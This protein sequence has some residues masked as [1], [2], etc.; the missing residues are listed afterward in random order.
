METTTVGPQFP[1]SFQGTKFICSLEDFKAVPYLDPG[2]D[3]NWVI[4]FGTE[5][6]QTEKDL[7][8]KGISRDTG[9]FLFSKHNEALQKQLA[10]TALVSLPFQYQKDAVFSLAY[11]MGFARFMESTIYK[12]LVAR[13]VDLSSWLEIIHGSQKQVMPGLVRRRGFEVRLFIYGNYSTE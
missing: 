10:K 1:V 2:G 7:Y 12:Q 6:T 9:M 3:G 4:G 8:E 13:S 11:N 5:I